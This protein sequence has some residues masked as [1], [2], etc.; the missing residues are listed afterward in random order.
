MCCQIPCHNI[1]LKFR[2]WR[3]RQ[4]K[5]KYR[6]LYKTNLR[7]ILLNGA[8]SVR[9][10]PTGY[11]HV[12]CLSAPTTSGKVMLRRAALPAWVYSHVEPTVFVHTTHTVVGLLVAT[13]QLLGRATPHRA[14]QHRLN[15]AGPSRTALD[16]A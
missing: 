8:V 4:T 9:T 11:C 6:L 14:C 1:F 3:F 10:T 13:P 7:L 16:R 15:Q 5:N 2:G 12:P